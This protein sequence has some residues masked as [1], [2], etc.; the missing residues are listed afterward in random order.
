LNATRRLIET[1]SDLNGAIMSKLIKLDGAVETLVS[2]SSKLEKRMEATEKQFDK[3]EA[4]EAEWMVSP[5]N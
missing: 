5:L 4:M 1:V 2:T 3:V